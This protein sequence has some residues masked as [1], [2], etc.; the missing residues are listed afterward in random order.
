MDVVPARNSS[1][2]CA[3]GPCPRSRR[4]RTTTTAQSIRRMRTAAIMTPPW[5]GKEVST[6]FRLRATEPRRQTCGPEWPDRKSS[7]AALFAIPRRGASAADRP[8]APGVARR[9]LRGAA[10]RLARCRRVR[11]RQV[12]AAPRSRP[13]LSAP[14]SPG[15]SATGPSNIALGQ[16]THE[17]VTRW[18]SALPLADP[19]ADRDDR[20]RVPQHPAAGRSPRRGR[21]RAS[22]TSPARP[23]DTLV[24]RLVAALDSRT[25]CAMVSTVLFET[26]EIVPGLDVLAASCR[27]HGVPLLLDAYHQLNVVPFD[28][29][30]RRPATMRSSPAADTSTA[31]WAKAI[32]FF[33]CRPA[34]ASAAG[35]DR[36]VRR[37]RRAR[38]SRPAGASPTAKARPRLAARP[39]TSRRTTARPPCSPSTSSRG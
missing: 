7:R 9:R 18:L 33:A 11:R 19:P 6:G 21:S 20:R 39:T 23:A 10:A 16:N 13:R 12:G 24:D 36:L 34:D 17:L 1:G 14:G 29:R 32:A 35:A 5:G 15:S 30:Q 2:R 3:P 28:L 8:L 4:R 37:V 22:S 38:R 27:R 31:S 26:A 25:A